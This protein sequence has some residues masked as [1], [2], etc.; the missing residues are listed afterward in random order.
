MTILTA[1]EVTPAA[2]SIA[3]VCPDGSAF[4]VQRPEE[5]PCKNARVVDPSSMP[6]LRPELLP[7]PYPWVLDQQARNPNNPYNLI[8]AAEKSRSAQTTSGGAP[9]TGQTSQGAEP[10]RAGTVPALTPDELRALI[11]LVDLRQELSRAELLAE[12]ALG[13]GRLQVRFAWSAALEAAVLDWLGRTGRG[14]RVL[15]FSARAFEAGEFHPNFFFLQDARGFRPNPGTP[16][17]VGFLVG[18]PGPLDPG[19]TRLGYVVLP[20]HFDPRAPMELWWNDRR[21]EA[22]LA[23]AASGAGGEG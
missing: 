2:S 15:L 17:E 16:A 12:D 9:G 18:D 23:A 19:A 21:I 7:R 22:T 1:A 11:E 13:R 4:V 8:E 14:D 3:G 20:A 10:R 6:P 5:V